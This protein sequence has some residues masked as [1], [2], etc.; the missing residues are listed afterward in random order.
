MIQDAT[1]DS[2]TGLTRT[3]LT[4][5]EGETMNA[6]KAVFVCAVHGFVVVILKIYP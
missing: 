1:L 6:T 2:P 3:E 4:E 5:D